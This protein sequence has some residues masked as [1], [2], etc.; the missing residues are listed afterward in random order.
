[1]CLIA[2]GTKLLRG[3]GHAE[4]RLYTLLWMFL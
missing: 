2:E 3:G 4:A 1:M